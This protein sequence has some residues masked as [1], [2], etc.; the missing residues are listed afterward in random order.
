[1]RIYFV[2]LNSTKQIMNVFQKHSL[3]FM[4]AP[5]IFL[6]RE[7]PF[8]LFL[9]VSFLF[10]FTFMGF[11]WLFG[12]CIDLEVILFLLLG[13]LEVFGI[14]CTLSLSFLCV[15]FENEHHYEFPICFLC[16]YFSNTCLCASKESV[17]ASECG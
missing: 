12:N 7:F 16:V 13:I 9:F 2:G 3:I 6:K 1:M 5:N 4:D 10:D 15:Y 17:C 11:V 14:P 8:F